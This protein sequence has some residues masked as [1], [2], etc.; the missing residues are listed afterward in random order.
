MLD[1]LSAALAGMFVWTFAEYAL[2][3][4]VFHRLKLKTLGRQEHLTHHS[5][6]GYFTPNHLKFKMSALGF[7]VVYLVTRLIIDVAQA[8][9]FTLSLA[10]SYA[11]Y[12]RVHRN[13]H[14]QAPKGWY[15][16]WLRKHHF[17]HHFH[18]ARVNHGV[19]TPF[20]DV[21]FGTYRSHDTVKVPRKFAM[22]WLLDE[23]G[24]VKAAYAHDY[25]TRN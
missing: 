7:T 1:Y 21:V 22:D 16:A 8:E 9:V 14:T 15:G 13:H 6:S 24:N 10:L 19:T 5:Q 12:E 20:W 11:W 23:Q 25:C 17:I 4:W 3:H 2:H 18:D